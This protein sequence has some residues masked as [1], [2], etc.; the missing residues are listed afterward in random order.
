[1]I[2]NGVYAMPRPTLRGAAFLAF[3]NPMTE[4]AADAPWA[5]ISSYPAEVA[6]GY[7]AG[8]LSQGAVKGLILGIVVYWIGRLLVRLKPKFPNNFAKIVGKGV[9]FIAIALGFY[10]AAMA[11]SM[12]IFMFNNNDS[13]IV[14]I[15]SVSLLIQIGFWYWFL[16]AGVKYF[17]SK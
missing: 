15:Y 4:T 2:I 11:V 13:S 10:V 7:A 16:G 8:F 6:F 9:Y 12:I 1:M 3:L 5:R 17:I 14:G